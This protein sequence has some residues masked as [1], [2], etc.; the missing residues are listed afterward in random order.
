MATEFRVLIASM[1]PNR[2]EQIKP[3]IL[4]QGD[5]GRILK[6]DG[7]ELPEYYE[8]HFG[9]HRSG[10]SKLTVGD[11]NGVEIPNEFL[12]QPG[13]FYA[14]FYL[15]DDETDGETRYELVLKVVGKAYAEDAPLPPEQ[16]S[17]ADQLLGA[18]SSGVEQTRD[19]TGAA[20]QFKMEAEEAA[21][22]AAEI[23]EEIKKYKIELEIIGTTLYL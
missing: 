4:Y 15:H 21:D 10:H 13:S 3:L 6:L 12:S 5:Y 11:R 19:L 18:L 2:M 20:E 7:V 9:Y 23:L 17:T 1:S 14:W 16:R 8:V 22:T